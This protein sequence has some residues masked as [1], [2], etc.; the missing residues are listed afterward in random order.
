MTLMSSLLNKTLVAAAFA[1]L[2]VDVFIG[3]RQIF[4]ADCYELPTRARES[5][6]PRTVHQSDD[7]FHV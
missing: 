1:A 7:T 5:D 4:L 6:W 2:P 3:T